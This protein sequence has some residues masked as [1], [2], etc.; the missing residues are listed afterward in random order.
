M[1]GMPQIDFGRTF[2]G[3][4]KSAAADE[5]ASHENVSTGRVDRL[6]WL[7]R[8][9]LIRIGRPELANIIF[10][11]IA[12]GGGLF[13]A[14]YFFNGTELLV[15]AARWPGELFYLRPAS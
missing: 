13:C 10:T 5:A 11:I 15:T 1:N 4:Q 14:F 8:S 6:A 7:T 2:S 3:Q 12:V 9:C